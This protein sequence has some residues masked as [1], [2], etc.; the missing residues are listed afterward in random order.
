MIVCFDD[1]QSLANNHNN[2]IQ[3]DDSDDDDM[4]NNS[5]KPS[6][7]Y[8]YRGTTSVDKQ[9]SFQVFLD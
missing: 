7:N 3:S 4:F 9:S 1:T 6:G 2:K 5:P 8:K